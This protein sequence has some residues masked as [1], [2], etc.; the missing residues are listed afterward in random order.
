CRRVRQS[1]DSNKSVQSH[2]KTIETDIDRPSVYL[3][4]IIR[5]KNGDY[6]KVTTTIPYTIRISVRRLRMIHLRL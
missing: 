4:D 6:D 3:S 1:N 2:A 5:M